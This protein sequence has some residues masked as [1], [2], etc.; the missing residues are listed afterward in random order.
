MNSTEGYFLTLLA[1]F[2][3]VFVCTFGSIEWYECLSVALCL[4]HFFKFIGD[5]GKN[6]SIKNIIAFIA[7]LQWLLG[8]VLGYYYDDLIYFNYRMS[9]SKITYFGYVLPATVLFL[10]GLYANKETYVNMQV[11][12]SMNIDYFRKGT[13]FIIFGFFA[14]FIPIPFLSYLLSGLMFIG[15]FY[16][17]ASTNKSKY[18][19]IAFVFGNLFLS[20]LGSGFFHELLLWGSFFLMIYFLT[21]P[22]KFWFRLL[23]IIVGFG[24]AYLIQLAKT[25]YREMLW[26]GEL[27]N[28]S[29]LG[30]FIS[31]IDKK[32]SE[33]DNM[34]S[35][36][37]GNIVVRLNQGWIISSVMNNVPSV[38]PYADGETIK[39]AIIASILPRILDPDKA[40]AGG[41]KNMQKYAGVELNLNTSMDI[42]QVGEAYAN[43]GPA[44]G[45]TA[46]STTSL[47]TVSVR[48]RAGLWTGF[49][50]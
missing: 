16:M 47:T 9:V 50:R 19:W 18:Y 7:T 42:S 17:F 26:S 8:A 5:L 33:P 41:H 35:N 44:G 24:C 36:Q 32:V 28:T 30:A 21:Y 46:D 20:S 40:I 22:K 11:L 12:R 48:K 23:I 43:F 29:K 1:S 25:D 6:I 31:T 34:A 2:F 37:L 38:E 15:V 49:D 45:C 13:F 39:N 4:T 14:R 27:A 10:A 3:V